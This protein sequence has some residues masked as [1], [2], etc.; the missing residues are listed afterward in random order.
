[1]NL[2]QYNIHI[3]LIFISI[4][5]YSLFFCKIKLSIIIVLDID[6]IHFI[7]AAFDHINNLQHFT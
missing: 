1:M 4:Y 2:N 3:F 7:P 5:F 6:C